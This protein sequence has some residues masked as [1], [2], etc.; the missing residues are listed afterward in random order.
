MG[1]PLH[2][3]AYSGI[4]FPFSRQYYYI[5]T[6]KFQSTT[7]APVNATASLNPTS[8]RYITKSAIKI[9][10]PT[11]FPSYRVQ[12][13]LAAVTST[14]AEVAAD[15]E[16]GPIHGAS[17]CTS[18]DVWVPGP[19]LSASAGREIW[20]FHAFFAIHSPLQISYD[21]VCSH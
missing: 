3:W 5:P 7:S 4:F 18:M 9:A 11:A 12:I 1:W 16:F 20:A 17:T 2:S 15:Q 13:W 8:I 19:I 6:V 10:S 21:M 14:V